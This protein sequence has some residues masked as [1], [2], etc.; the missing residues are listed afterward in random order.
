MEE[1]NL[2]L[3][4]QSFQK[5]KVGTIVN[6]TVIGK[7]GDPNSTQYGIVVNIGGK[8]DGLISAAE[9]KEFEHLEK[10]AK[11]DVMIQ[12]TRAVE[13]VIGVSAKKAVDIVAAN[14]QIDGVRS[15]AKFTATVESASKSGL[16]CFFGSWRVFV[17]ASEVEEYFVRD[18]DRYKGKPIELV[19]TS[20]DNEKNQIIASRKAH[21]VAEKTASAE[22]FWN[23]IFVN[24]LVTGKVVRITNF[25][26]F[27][28]VDGVDCLVH[29]AEVSHDRGQS[30]KDAFQIG[31]EYSFRVI[32]L[33]QE[34][35]RVQ[36]SHKATQSHPFDDNIESILEGERYPVVIKRLLP[37]GVIARFENGL[38]GM[39]HISE[40]SDDYVQAIT[41]VCKVGD[42]RDAMVIGIDYENR[43]IALSL[44][45]Y[46]MM[47]E[48]A[49]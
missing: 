10:G 2:D 31:S 48:G 45:S 8:S 3:I 19:A 46:E 33:D 7:R 25:G 1:F 28:N 5:Y 47:E 40:L 15:G 24:K 35:G 39:I 18:L 21:V 20:F 49:E 29:N 34:A 37:Y 11:I 44:K 32:S 22:L 43:K 9:V 38:E 14:T 17:P 6:A 12:T 4:E 30:A 36:L 41:E 26:A 23:G 27:V 13:G 16:T 42:A